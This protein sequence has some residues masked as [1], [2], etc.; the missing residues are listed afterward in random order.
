MDNPIK[1]VA[2]SLKFLNKF[3]T[4]N[5]HSQQ[6]W[7][8][9]ECMFTETAKYCNECMDRKHQCAVHKWVEIE[10]DKKE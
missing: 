3:D 6:T 10:N 8:G 7:W 2:K 4:K 9:W 5:D 1:N